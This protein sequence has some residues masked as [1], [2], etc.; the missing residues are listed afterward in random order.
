MWHIAFG[1]YC[2]YYHWLFDSVAALTFLVC[3]SMNKMGIITLRMLKHL[4]KLLYISEDWFLN[5][6]SHLQSHPFYT[7]HCGA[8]GIWVWF[9]WA[10]AFQY[11]RLFHCSLSQRSESCFLKLFHGVLQSIGSQRVGHESDWTELNWTDTFESSSY[12]FF[13]LVN[14]FTPV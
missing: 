2:Y 9:P 11:S 6:L 14:H 12:L 5:I 8:L 3:F 1:K 7:L 10:S 4:P 13:Y